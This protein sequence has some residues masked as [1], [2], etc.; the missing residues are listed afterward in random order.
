M[1]V[2][3]PRGVSRAQGGLAL[4]IVAAVA[5]SLYIGY[6]AWSGSSFPVK[7]RPFG[8]YATVVSTQFNGTEIYYGVEW[9]TSSGFVPL[10]AQITSPQTD[11]A[12]SP[13]CGLDLSAATRGQMLDLPFA[14]TAPKQS[15]ASVD[16]AIAVRQASNMTEFTIVYHIDQINA[17]PGKI[18]PSNFACSQPAGSSM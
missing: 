5:F 6:L 9:N 8:D 13:V 1:K 18:V 14:I 17:Q 7:E 11:E 16:L 4:V 10:Y 2:G 12:N 3:S 15:L